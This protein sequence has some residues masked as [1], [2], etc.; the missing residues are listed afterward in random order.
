MTEIEKRHDTFDTVRRTGRLERC[1]W[2]NCVRF[3]FVP[4]ACARICHSAASDSVSIDLYL[5]PALSLSISSFDD[6]SVIVRQQQSPAQSLANTRK[7][8]FDTN[9]Q[10]S[11]WCSVLSSTRCLFF[12]AVCSPY[13]TPLEWKSI[14][15]THTHT[16]SRMMQTH[17]SSPLAHWQIHCVVLSERRRHHHLI[18]CKNKPT[19][20]IDKTH[21][22]CSIYFRWKRAVWVRASERVRAY[23]RSKTNLLYSKFRIKRKH[24]EA[25]LCWV[26]NNN[27]RI[28]SR[29]IIC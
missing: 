27:V 24:K 11:I 18:R 10:R 2:L 15:H 23:V 1:E 17:A 28:Y 12:S 8:H 5:S 7:A 20:E 22:N 6:D 19:H 14:V 25:L 29:L 26:Y 3:N 4:C 9:F 13:R 21:K 16:H